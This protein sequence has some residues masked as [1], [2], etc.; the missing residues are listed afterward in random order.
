MVAEARRDRE[1]AER[2]TEQVRA[3]LNDTELL[4][5]S[6]QEQLAELKNVMQDMASD[7]DDP[8][9]TASTAPSTPALPSNNDFN[10]VF[11]AL[12]IS[13]GS[14]GVAPAPP[15]S[16]SHLLSPVLRTDVQSYE[17]FRSLLQLSRT[18]TPPSRVTS[19]SYSGLNIMNATSSS[20]RDQVTQGGRLPSNGSATSL[21]TS[22]TQS[23][24]TTTSNT[25]ASAV[26]S[27]PSRDAYPSA[28]P[29]KETRFYKRALSEDI[30][31]SLRLDTAPGLSWLARRTVI[32]SM[33]EGSLV[34]EPMPPSAKSFIFSCALCGENRKGEE[35]ARNHRFRTSENDNAQ[36][37]P[38]CAY[39]L[40]RMRATC[41]FLGFL[42][43]IKDGHW[44]TEGAESEKI[45]WEESVRLRERMFWARIGGGCVPAFTCARD[46]PRPSVEDPTQPL[47]A[48]P[49]LRNEAL[50]AKV[51]SSQKAE[52][53]HRS[54]D[55]LVEEP[56]KVPVH[57][58]EYRDDDDWETA[59]EAAIFDDISS[60]KS[61]QKLDEDDPASKQLQTDLRASLKKI[62]VK[63]S[64]EERSDPSSAPSEQQHLSTKIPGSFNF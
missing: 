49:F 27:V 41:D 38:L 18:S 15:T 5:A 52:D 39:C 9:T 13:P 58:R 54:K 32:N 40:N 48:P 25:P 24:A 29:L 23:S 43:M 34:I 10:K 51:H 3:Q 17:D 20:H 6:H 28:I 30:E 1:A 60:S 14:E 16:F 4:L 46:S 55:K 35:L 26:S 53:L 37:Y 33:C 59:K 47:S 22:V 8:D 42:R 61:P 64:H 7:R 45:A 36:R 19:G 21:S 2:R 57:R 11:E 12:H 56:Y 31:P 44:R 62:S 63:A 50:G